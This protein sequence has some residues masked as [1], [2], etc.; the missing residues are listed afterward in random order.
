VELEHRIVRHVQSAV[1]GALR[2]PVTALS[3]ALAEF[4]APN[5]LVAYFAALYW[6]ND[7]YKCIYGVFLI[8]FSVH[9]NGHIKW[10]F[11]AGRPCWT[12]ATILMRDWS[13]E[14]SFPSGHAQIAWALA[15][16]FSEC[17]KGQKSHWLF[18]D[19]RMYFFASVVA[20]SRVYMG[21]HYPSDVIVGAVVGVLLARLYLIAVPFMRAAGKWSTARKVCAIQLVAALSW[22]AISAHHTRAKGLPD[23]D[24][25]L[26]EIHAGK[27]IDPVDVPYTHWIGMV[28][29]LSGLG[30]AMP[31]LKQVELSPPKPGLKCV[32]RLLLGYSSLLSIYFALRLLEK[33]LPAGPLQML[34]RFARF[35]SVAPTVYLLMPPIFRTLG[36]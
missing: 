28:G 23:L 27:L 6:L 25:R 8:P 35:A 1:P 31:F 13:E 15:T 33:V 19:A 11:R 2:G 9:L 34:A 7:K 22:K 26:W 4:L 10:F 12:D 21:V 17:N 18:S 29:V 3:R 24:L 36:I 30:F 20:L 14:Y 32:L 5:G 16:F